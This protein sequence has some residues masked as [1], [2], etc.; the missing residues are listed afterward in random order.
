MRAEATGGFRVDKGQGPACALKATPVAAVGWMG[1]RCGSED[2]EGP[3]RAFGQT[4]TWGAVLD[5]GD[6]SGEKRGILG[7]ASNNALF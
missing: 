5:G 7:S 4:G 1:G 2:Q 6:G 3:A